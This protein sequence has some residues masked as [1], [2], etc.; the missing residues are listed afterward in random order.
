[1][2]RKTI[3]TRRNIRYFGRACSTFARSLVSISNRG[4]VAAA[5]SRY[6]RCRLLEFYLYLYR[7]N[8]AVVRKK[9]E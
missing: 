7:P 4:S 2:V 6:R 1:M 9:R 5:S 8:I 3:S